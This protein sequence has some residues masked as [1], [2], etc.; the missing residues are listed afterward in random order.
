MFHGTDIHGV[1]GIL[2]EGTEPTYGGG[3]W[4][5]GFYV[6]PDERYAEDYA[7]EGDDGSQGA[8]VRGEVHAENPRIFKDHDEV[9]SF[10][11]EN[12]RKPHQ[13]E[14]MSSLVRSHGH[15]YFQVD[16]IPMGVVLRR[17]GF[18]PKALKEANLD[19]EGWHE[20]QRNWTDLT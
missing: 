5:Q 12:G 19:E 10:L 18:H 2:K 3:D 9:G 17:G 6:T 8:V 11:Q 13:T 4:G 15:D 20:W 7:R 14:D 16:S 1:D